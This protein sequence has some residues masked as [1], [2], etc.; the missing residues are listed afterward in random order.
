M[1]YVGVCSVCCPISEAGF[2]GLATGL[3]LAGYKPIVTYMFMDFSL[4]A[5]IFFFVLFLYLI[6]ISELLLLDFPI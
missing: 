1:F 5:I 6:I 4:L 3:A 2:T